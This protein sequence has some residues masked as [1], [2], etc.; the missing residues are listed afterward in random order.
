MGRKVPLSQLQGSL[1]PATKVVPKAP[2]QKNIPVLLG[3]GGPQ[4]CPLNSPLPFPPNSCWRR[5]AGLLPLT[6]SR[7]GWH[8]PTRMLAVLP[9]SP[10][11]PLRS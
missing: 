5:A 8:L 11:H 2:R 9:S 3:R 10:S 4:K 7:P 6:S 1:R